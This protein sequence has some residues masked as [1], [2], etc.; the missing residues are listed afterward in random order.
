MESDLRQLARG[1]LD[2]RAAKRAL[3]LL[4]RLA[5]GAPLTAE[6][7][8]LLVEHAA[9]FSALGV[10]AQVLGLARHALASGVGEPELAKIAAT[11]A[12]VASPAGVELRLR[13]VTLEVDADALRVI[14]AFMRGELE[15]AVELSKKHEFFVAHADAP[16]VYALAYGALSLAYA[17]ESEDPLLLLAEW[18]QRHPDAAPRARQFVLRARGWIHGLVGEHGRELA[19]VSEAHALCEE[20]GLGVERAFVDVERG[21]ALVRDGGIEAAH[22]I[23]AT[24][25]KAA[26]SADGLLPAYRDLLRLELALHEGDSPGALE[27]ARRAHAYFERSGNV[28]LACDVLF[29][30]CL[31]QAFSDGAKGALDVY[32]R[33]VQRSP[34]AL[35]RKNLRVLDA[36]GAA[37]FSPGARLCTQSH[38]S[39]AEGT[40]CAVH[41]FRPPLELRHAD[42]Y[43]DQVRGEVWLSG[44]GPFPLGAH[45]VVESVLVLLL[46]SGSD[47]LLVEDLYERVWGG[48]FHPLRHENK[49]HVTLHRLR[50]WLSS[51]SQG[52]DALVVLHCGRVRISEA[53][54]ASVCTLVAG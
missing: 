5:D 50:Q 19:L 12:L 3:E 24:F 16:H 31:A 37:L 27:A 18:E 15:R 49:V 43:L 38:G 42:I 48:P 13:S 11:H 44:R 29:G 41:L 35:H 14:S 7:V 36:L 21:L 51:R 53:A 2:A 54:R 28:V 39:T 22:A 47:G 52:A 32:R 4:G 23:A 10:D 26:A 9:L 46:V 45:P 34:T 20:H 30:A 25:P 1:S 33:A 40:A 8:A 6:L 17:K